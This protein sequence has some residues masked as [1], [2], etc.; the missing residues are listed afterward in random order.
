MEREGGRK[1]RLRFCRSTLF[2]SFFF[3]INLFYL[4]LAAFG[5]CCCPGAFS[6]CGEQGLLFVSGRGLLIGVASFLGEHGL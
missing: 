4:F 2:R 6:S 1:S 5:L 3:K